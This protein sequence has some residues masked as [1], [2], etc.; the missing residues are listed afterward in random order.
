[1]G[2]ERICG[3]GD[4][5]RG[6]SQCKG[7]EGGGACLGCSRKSMEADAAERVSLVREAK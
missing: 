4:P 5:G 7:P 2:H 6:N 3:K 1:M